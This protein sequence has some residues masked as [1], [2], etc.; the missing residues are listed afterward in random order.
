MKSIIKPFVAIVMVISILLSIPNFV[1]C[2]YDQ[3]RTDDTIF[4]QEN[5]TRVTGLISTYSISVKKDGSNLLLAA[6]I[7]CNSDVVKSGFKKIVVQRRGNGTSSWTDYVTYEDLYSN[8]PGHLFTKSISIS[9]S[10]QYRAVCT[11]YAKKNILLVEKFDATS[12][13]V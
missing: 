11:F 4:V 2:A 6:T 1:V 7:A 8:S 12:N 13:I 9:T 3:E 5:N 10:Y